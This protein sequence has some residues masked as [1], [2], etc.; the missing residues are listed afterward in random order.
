MNVENDTSYVLCLMS[1]LQKGQLSLSFSVVAKTGMAGVGWSLV[2]CCLLRFTS[3]SSSG[4]AGEVGS[5]W[6]SCISPD[7]G[8][9]PSFVGVMS[10]RG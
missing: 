3:S 9:F 1:T 10:G 8:R 4:I 2:R 7:V 5:D 6:E